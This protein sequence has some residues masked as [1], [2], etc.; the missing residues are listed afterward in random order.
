[1]ALILYSL[2]LIDN[3]YSTIILLSLFLNE[4]RSCCCVARTDMDT[5]IIDH[6]YLT[7]VHSVVVNDGS[8]LVR[9]QYAL[10]RTYTYMLCSILVLKH[11]K[12]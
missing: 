6:R 5:I 12:N 2:D 8:Y 3:N 7:I 10:Q 1:M 11:S 9:G 4:Y